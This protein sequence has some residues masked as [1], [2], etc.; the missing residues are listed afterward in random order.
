MNTNFQYV[1]NQENNLVE[2]VKKNFDLLISPGNIGFYKSCE[3]TKIF[4]YTPGEDKYYNLF[5]L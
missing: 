2:R 5:T 3:I 4:F 1:D